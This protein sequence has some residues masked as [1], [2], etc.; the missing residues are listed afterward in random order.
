MPGVL[1][2]T[3]SVGAGHDVPAERFAAD[4]R[5]RNVDASVADGIAAIG[6][7][8]ERTIASATEYDTPFGN[9]LFDLQHYLGVSFPPGRR[10]TGR[11]LQTLGARGLLDL[12]ARHRP[13]IVVSTYPGTTELLGRLRRA[14]RFE[15]PLV[16]AITDLA[17]LRLWAH[18]GVDLH[19]VTHP[20]SVP[21]VRAIAGE[22]ADVVAVRG[23]NPAGF[24]APPSQ[25]SA[26][27]SLGLPASGSIVLV[28]GGGWGVGDVAGA[29]DVAL[30][31]G[32]DRVMVLCGTN[33]ALRARLSDDPRVRAFGFTERMP[34]LLSA[35]DVLV[36]STAGLTVLEALICGT[37]VIS[38]GWARGH[39][40]INNVAFRRHGLA[41]VARDETQ[42]AAALTRALREPATPLRSWFALPAAADVLRDRFPMLEEAG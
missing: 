23:F 25:A 21:E 30:R 6:G 29:V 7:L 34:E 18:P 10:L 24:E 36:H 40:R 28:S 37:R 1:I 32:A 12:V 42:L 9:R 16:A 20:E 17:S 27:G 11:L 38:Y 15:V 14:G 35:A 2:L 4:L 33:A 31:V 41:E 26:R 3:A 39:I 8:V 13:S 5:A 22:G 19:L